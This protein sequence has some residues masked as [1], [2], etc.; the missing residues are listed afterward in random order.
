MDVRDFDSA[1]SVLSIDLVEGRKLFGSDSAAAIV[2]ELQ[3]GGEIPEHTTEEDVLFMVL[4]GNPTLFINGESSSGQAQ[5]LVPCAGGILKGLKNEGT[6][7]ARVLV[8][9]LIQ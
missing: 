2:I 3:P 9:K 4:E 6:T 8:V 7:N 1:E 5:Q